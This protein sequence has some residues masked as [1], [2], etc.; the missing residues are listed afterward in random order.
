MRNIL[1]AVLLVAAPAAAQE[2]TMDISGMGRIL[3][4]TLA[5]KI[6]HANRSVASV[7]SRPLQDLLGDLE[8]ADPMVR[9]VAIQQL[10]PYVKT[11]LLVRKRIKSCLADPAVEI[12]SLSMVAL[13]N[14]AL[15]DDSIRLAIQEL[16]L[17]DDDDAIKLSGMDILWPRIATD[18]AVRARV[19]EILQTPIRGIDD[20]F[21]VDEA[22]ISVMNASVIVGDVEIREAVLRILAYDDSWFITR[23][24]IS[25]TAAEALLPLCRDARV[26]AA[27]Q[28]AAARGVGG[29]VHTL[30]DCR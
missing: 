21:V 9:L 1:F 8:D 15:E 29:A 17:K 25:S 24:L 28:T 30:S 2:S 7:L 18:G 20:L 11:N 13:G 19:L 6:K 27:L 4:Q 14:V 16:F 26:R 10:Q 23:G 12:R 3:A 22:V 5:L